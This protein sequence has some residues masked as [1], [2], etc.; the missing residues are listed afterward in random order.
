MPDFIVTRPWFGVKAGQRVSLSKVHPALIPHL[1]P[2]TFQT[3]G[4]SVAAP[5]LSG[6]PDGG[7]GVEID[8]VTDDGPTEFDWETVRADLL[9]ELHDAGIEHDE[10]AP[11]ADLAA[12]LDEEVRE[13]IKM[14]AE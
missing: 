6:Q 1:T 10:D 2:A 7:L 5:E 13:G 14:A 12:L 11:A 4:A 9:S 8:T 3:E